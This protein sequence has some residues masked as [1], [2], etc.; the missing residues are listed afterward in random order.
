MQAALV[1]IVDPDGS[2]RGDP[3]DWEDMGAA[4]ETI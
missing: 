1:V 4:E 2:V 3:T